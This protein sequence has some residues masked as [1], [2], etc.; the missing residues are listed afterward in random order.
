MKQTL[1]AWRD[2]LDRNKVI[3]ETAAASLLSLM[4]I[5]VAIAQT[6]TASRQTELMALQ[7]RISEAQ[8][9]PQFD[10]ALH[11]ELDQVTNKFDDNVLIVTNRGG[12]IRDFYA[13]TAFFLDVT[14]DLDA[15]GGARKV[16][17]PLNDYF[18]ASFIASASSGQLVRMVGDHNNAKVF[19]LGRD[20]REG[21]QA[22]RWSFSFMEER[23]LLEL[24]YR[25]LLDRPHDEYYIVQV[26]G[27][28][29]R[30]PD[31]E[32]KA[33]VKQWQGAQRLELGKLTADELLA[34]VRAAT[35]AM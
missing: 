24:Q 14:A 11:Q 6:W 2:W 30:V 12:P 13:R 16:S 26:V 21:A 33:L 32:G 27:G 17:V 34:F 28:G 22:K 29:R 23:L 31:E 15:P 8:A 4:A 5:I 10:I 1:T 35:T 19:A 20:L 9:L 25:D 18:T 3:F 7:T